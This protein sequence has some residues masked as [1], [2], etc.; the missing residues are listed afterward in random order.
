MN[1]ESVQAAHAGSGVAGY[2]IVASFLMV[3]TGMELTVF[4]VTALKPVLVPLLLTLAA[5]KFGLVAMFYMHLHY[6]RWALSAVF[7][8]PL[9]IAGAV[10]VSLLLLFL[11][12]HHH[13]G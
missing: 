13:P 10:L 6:E 5:A 9:A 11:Y 1:E 2:L 7:F 3:L 12:L 8:F 4:Y